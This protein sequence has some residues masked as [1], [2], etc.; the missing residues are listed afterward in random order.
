MANIFGKDSDDEEEQPKKEETQQEEGQNEDDDDGEIR[1]R[2]E[3]DERY[4]L[5]SI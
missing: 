5:G 2:H 4:F 1:D 3:R